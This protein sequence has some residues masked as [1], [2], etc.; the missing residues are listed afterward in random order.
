MRWPEY[1]AQT[2]ACPDRARLVL[3]AMSGTSSDGVTVALIETAGYALRRS[4]RLVAHRTFEYPSELRQRIFELY[5]P[6]RFD[7]GTLLRMA[8]DVA[9]A[10]ADAVNALLQEAGVA[11]EQAHLLSVHGPT[12]YYAPPG[13]HNQ[14]RGGFLELMEPRSAS[15]ATSCCFA[16][17]PVGASSRTS[18]V[19][20][21]PR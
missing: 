20:P 12:V 11:P 16:I 1:L 18:G 7:A 19:S 4:V 5:P 13:P 2:A 15:S 3:G 6:K 17:P 10:F 14:G 9:A 8:L 21:T